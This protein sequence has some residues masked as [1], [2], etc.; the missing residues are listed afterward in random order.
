MSNDVNESEVRPEDDAEEPKDR[1]IGRGRPD[2]P[3]AVE[4]AKDK[5]AGDGGNG[6][7]ELPR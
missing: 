6:R 3:S 1:T 5:E 4:Q 7:R 2:A